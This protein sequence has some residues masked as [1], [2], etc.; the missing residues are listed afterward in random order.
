MNDREITVNHCSWGGYFSFLS[1][2][3]NTSIANAITSINAS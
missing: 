1:L 2:S 3:A